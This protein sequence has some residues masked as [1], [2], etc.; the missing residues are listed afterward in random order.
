MPLWWDEKAHAALDGHHNVTP[1]FVGFFVDARRTDVSLN[2]KHH[3]IVGLRH[4]VLATSPKVRVV[5]VPTLHVTL[6]VVEIVGACASRISVI[7]MYARMSHNDTGSAV[8]RAALI[9]CRREKTATESAS[10]SYW[11]TPATCC[12]P[13]TTV[14]S[15]IPGRQIQPCARNSR[16]S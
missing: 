4:A 14:A 15:R 3:I 13:S 5:A 16:S 7:F 1:R 10:R 2:A 8:A 9:C 12:S 11:P 6:P